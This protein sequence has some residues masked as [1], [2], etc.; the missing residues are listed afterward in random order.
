MAKQ[1]ALWKYFTNKEPMKEEV[2]EAILPK[3]DRPLSTSMPSSTIEAANS[4]VRE[5]LLTTKG[6]ITVPTCDEDEA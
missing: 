4:S 1:T 5:H 6:S 2:V 3:P